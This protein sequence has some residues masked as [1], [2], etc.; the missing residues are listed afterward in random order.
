VLIY[1]DI[2]RTINFLHIGLAMYAATLRPA[3]MELKTTVDAKQ[4]LNQAAVLDGV[5]LTAFILGAAIERAKKVIADHAFISLSTNG[6]LALVQLLND[7]LQPN[8]D[9]K[10]LMNLEDFPSRTV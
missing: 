6:Q 2:G 10:S 9:M 3:R 4:L 8:E 7:P 5:D 1:T